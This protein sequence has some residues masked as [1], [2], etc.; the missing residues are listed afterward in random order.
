MRLFAKA[1]LVGLLKMQPKHPHPPI[2]LTVLGGIC[3]TFFL[4]SV[5]RVNDTTQ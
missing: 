2:G 1:P 3:R 5:A 4:L